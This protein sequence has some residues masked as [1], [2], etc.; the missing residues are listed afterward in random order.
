MAL[1]EFFPRL[2]GTGCTI[3]VQDFGLKTGIKQAPK[4]EKGGPFLR[5]N[6]ACH[7]LSNVSWLVS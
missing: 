4:K 3:L 6:K 7:F 5:L 2:I 1:V